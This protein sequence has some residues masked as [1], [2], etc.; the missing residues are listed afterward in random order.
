MPDEK[1]AYR[2]L[3]GACLT[4]LTLVFMLLYL[5]AKVQVLINN[6]DY[7][8]QVHTED[9]L[10]KD[11]DQFGFSQGF[12]VGAG[13]PEWGKDARTDIPAEIGSLKFYKKNWNLEADAENNLAFEEVETRPC[14]WHDFDHSYQ[15]QRVSSFS[16]ANFVLDDQAEGEMPIF[17]PTKSNWSALI[18]VWQDFLCVAEPEDL[19]IN[20][21]FDTNQG[22]ALLVVFETCDD[23]NLPEGVEQ[24]ASRQDRDDWMSAR[25]FV[26]LEN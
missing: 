14:E 25:Y 26:T 4:A 24:C 22:T 20:G 6:E 1:D 16:E 5:L 9:R 8:V 13:I 7:K 12:M 21:N 19:F 15:A 18:N 23:E 3:T 11:T 17:Y 2:T 10:Y